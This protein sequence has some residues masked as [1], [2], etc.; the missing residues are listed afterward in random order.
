M[1]DAF[2]TGIDPRPV[3]AIARVEAGPGTS[4]TVDWVGGG[5]IR[6]DLAGWIALH[7]IEFLRVPAIFGKPEV[8][9]DGYCVQWAGDEDLC[10]DSVHLDL[11]AERQTPFEASDLTAWQ[12]RWHLSNQEAAELFGVS[13]NMW[14]NC[15]NGAT[16]IPG[17]VIVA[18]RAMDRDPLLFEANFRPRRNGGPPAVG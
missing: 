8:A 5:G 13:P 3:P 14:L 6:V 9:D 12:A 7:D 16:D 4:L 1:T 2:V 11:I 17:G 18:I 10:I 15:K